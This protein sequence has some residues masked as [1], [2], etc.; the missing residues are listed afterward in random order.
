MFKTLLVANRG[1]IAVRVMQTARAMGIRTVA[2]Y[3]DADADALHV[4]Q[5]DVAV[6]IGPA[7]ARESYLVIPAI[8]AAADAEGVDAIHPGYGF[9]S[10]SAEFAKAVADRGITWVGPSP[11]CIVQM[12]DKIRARNL[13]ADAGIPVARGTTSPV[14]AVEDA[15]AAADEVGFPLIVKAAAGG[16]GIG[17]AAVESREALGKAF[18]T[19]RTRAERFFGDP[20]IL[21]EQLIAPARHVEVQI[22]GLADGTVISLG[23]R[24]CSLQRRHQ[25][26]IEESPSPGVTSETRDLMAAAARD[27]GSAIGYR[28]AGTVEFLVNPNS[29]EFVFLE[30]NT[31]LQVEHPIT[32]LTHDVD[33]VAAQLRVAAGEPV[34]FDVDRT[35]STGHAIEMRLYAEDPHTF[36]PSA[37]AIQEWHL[38]AG[39]GIR[40]DAGYRQGD[41]VTPNYDPLLAKICVHGE[42]RAEALELA[43]K[44]VAAVHVVGVKTNAPLIAEV[45]ASEHV[46]SGEYDTRTLETLLR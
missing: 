34:D 23:D 16:G 40:I 41:K 36:L 29:Q 15:L 24:D 13:M 44:A 19:A 39:D 35:G 33:L 22:L 26:V 27:A 31:R 6:R 28:G 45:L 4:E 38:P 32:E 46:T 42:T 25:K 17:M 5:A 30:M 43:Q 9:L 20:S 7:A 11:E 3:S 21:L 18:T 8:L 2:V 37:G 12:G 10:E 14:V 1:E